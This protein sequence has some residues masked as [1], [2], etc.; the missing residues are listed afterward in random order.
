MDEPQTR[1]TDET[2]KPLGAPDP[3]TMARL[4]RAATKRSYDH[5]IEAI[6]ADIK[7]LLE[8]VATLKKHRPQ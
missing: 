5:A 6:E 3:E 8:V 7:N 4:Y 2:S 1:M